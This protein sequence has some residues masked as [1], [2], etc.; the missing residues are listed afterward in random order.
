MSSSS[1][2]L[3]FSVRDGA[4]FGDRDREGVAML[5]GLVPL[6]LPSMEMVI[7]G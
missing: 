2:S 5:A 3:I 1:S 7:A 6:V 4:R